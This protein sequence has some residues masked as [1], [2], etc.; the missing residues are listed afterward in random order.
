[1]YIST[2]LFDTTCVFVDAGDEDFFK[3]SLDNA[4]ALFEKFK[5]QT[6]NPDVVKQNTPIC[7][8]STLWKKTDE[9]VAV[10]RKEVHG[11]RARRKFIMIDA[12]FNPGE[13]AESHLMQEK[14]KA[15]AEKH[16]TPLMLYPTV[17][18]PT[19]PRFRAVL[20]SKR[21]MNASQ[22]YQAVSWLFQEIDFTPNDNS[23]LRINMN[24]NLPV[25]INQAQVDNVYS[26]F[27]LKDGGLSPLD[28][29]LWKEMP[30]PPK[31]KPSN[32]I[33]VDV[34]MHD[35]SFDEVKLLEGARRM[36]KSKIALQYET[37]WRVVASIAAAVIRESISENTAH[38]ML[39]VL[40]EAGD[41]PDRSAYWKNE[42]RKLLVKQ[43]SEI[44]ADPAFK[45][46]VTRP[47]CSYSEF[48]TAVK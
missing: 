21:G 5:D 34:T 32:E 48:R 46:Q 18:F 25:F 35:F 19:K 15:L 1:M 38:A 45:L 2:C 3:S 47:L 33:E 12:D 40:A 29:K 41:D 23:D 7:H 16:K 42:N 13:E 28:N 30:L 39:D 14:L 6:V 9:E 17:S 8:V 27:K 20:L 24:R 37:F 26:T 10:S 11:D 44:S 36:S 22:Y 43:M 4:I 31:F